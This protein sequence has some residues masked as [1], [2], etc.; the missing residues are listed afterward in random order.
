[1]PVR[2]ADV[3]ARLARVGV[4]LLRERRYPLPDYVAEALW[5]YA[6]GEPDATEHL[7]DAMRRWAAGPS[8]GP[9]M[10]ADVLHRIERDRRAALAEVEARRHAD[11]QRADLDA[12]RPVAY[13]LM[14][15]EHG[16]IDGFRVE[17][18]QG[19][20]PRLSWTP[21]A[22]RRRERHLEASP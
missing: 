13:V 4:R 6:R 10:V 15:Y 5:V 21:R 11:E 7:H 17:Q 2:A 14:W 20:R 9:W 22:G 1:M 8:G 18:A 12:E 3:G 16:D 19:D